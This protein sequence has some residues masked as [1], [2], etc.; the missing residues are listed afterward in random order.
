MQFSATLARHMA[1]PLV[2]ACCLHSACFAK[3]LPDL[4]AYIPGSLPT[5]RWDARPEAAAWTAQTM[6]VVAAHDAELAN[7]VPADI[8]TFCPRYPNATLNERRAFWVGLLSATAKHESG[9]NPRAAGGGGRYVG[10]M[11]ISP[12]TASHSRCAA[13]SATDLKDGAANLACAV[14]I[15]A[16]KVAQDG[17]VAG[18]GKYGI[19]RDWGP[20]QNKVARAEIAKW[21][22]KQ[23]YCQG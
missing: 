17:V 10:L 18:N 21:T 4:V 3:T 23:S 1:L 11:Q 22:A 2:L 14:Q 16:P 12:R 13:R 6:A 19:G 5:M 8:A 9:F 20:F 15:A 7:T